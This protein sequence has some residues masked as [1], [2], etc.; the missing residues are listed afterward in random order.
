MTTDLPSPEIMRKL[1]RYE[2]ETGR[3]FWLPRSA[4]MFAT[5]RAHRAWNT[6]YSFREAFI[7][8]ESGGYKQGK[9]YN[10]IYQSHRVIWAMEHNEWPEGHIDH[11]NG[12]REDN[13][14]DNLR[15]VS[16][17]ENS[18]NRRPNL[19][20]ASSLPHGVSK[21]RTGSFEARIKVDGK[22]RYIG[23]FK[24]AKDASSAYQNAKY[25]M[26]FHENHG[27]ALH[28]MEPDA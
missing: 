6:K 12:N 25:A 4:D 26:G 15:V 9:I 17:C 2:P 28:S 5:N 14:I 16:P 8:T 19:H 7:S 20:K 13:K 27:R 10:K 23:C 18:R 1:L 3:L 22:S 11:I 21:T 24:A